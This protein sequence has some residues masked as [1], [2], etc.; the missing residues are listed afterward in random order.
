MNIFFQ[1]RFHAHRWN[2]I[3]SKYLLLLVF[4]I[5]HF[6]PIMAQPITITGPDPDGVSER[7]E[8]EGMLWM[9]T[10]SDE[11]DGNMGFIWFYKESPNSSPDTVDFSFV[12]STD[13]SSILTLPAVTDN[14]EGF[15]YCEV[16]TPV[17]SENSDE[18]ELDVFQVPEANVISIPPS[19]QFNCKV[20]T[21]VLDGTSSSGWISISWSLNGTFFSND[22]IIVA[23]EP[24]EYTL[25]VTNVCGSH[26]TIVD[27]GDNDAT[28]QSLNI[29][30]SPDP[31]T[32]SC[33]NPKVT[34]TAE[35]SSIDF[36]TSYWR[37]PD[38]TEVVADEYEAFDQGT[39]TFVAFHDV[40]GCPDS[41]SIEVEKDLS[42]FPAADVSSPD[43]FTCIVDST[44]LSITSI[45]QTT[46]FQWIHP[47]GNSLGSD[48]TITAR[49]PGTFLLVLFKNACSDTI[50]IEVEE[51]KTPPVVT[52]SPPNPTICEGNNIDI[53]ASGADSYVWSP[54]GQTTETITVDEPAVYIVEA[55]S[56][57]NG[58]TASISVEVI[59]RPTPDLVIPNDEYKIADG[60]S[61]TIFLDVDPPTTVA[62][63]SV[64]DRLNANTGSINSGE[65]DIQLTYNLDSDRATGFVTFSVVPD[66]EGCLG[67]E[68]TVN[69]FIQS[70]GEIFIP[71]VITPNGDGANDLWQIGT[72]DGVELTA[73]SIFNRAGG[74]VAD[75]NPN[76]EWDANNC[77]DGVYFYV[78]QFTVNGEPMVRKGA[79]TVLRSTN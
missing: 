55:T 11:Q 36:N 45:Q 29:A 51:N 28:P 42:D 9:V 40:S 77:A 21:I 13:T 3:F 27:I 73:I 76:E 14:D 66:N 74:K 67:D 1:S 7:C 56:N 69:V 5:F 44:L 2:A 54:D 58:C 31:P 26:S 61:I 24:G 65:G 38:L 20:D 8:G 34:L 33:A 62:D 41:T 50:E 6:K 52:I 48:T 70:K 63:W 10:A 57:A 49:V 35:G 25:T 23:T 18:V 78:I 64:L 15:Y 71:E 43:V 37:L 39:Y 68:Q 17:A 46:F 19:D 4:L 75:L 12:F 16:S 72:D 53:T 32:I 47:T 22:E 79:V 59:Q 30:P 60:E